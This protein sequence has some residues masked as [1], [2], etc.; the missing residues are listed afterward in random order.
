MCGSHRSQHRLPPPKRFSLSSSADSRSSLDPPVGK[1]VLLPLSLPAPSAAPALRCCRRVPET[2][3]KGCAGMS[4]C[5]RPR[6]SRQAPRCSAPTALLAAKVWEKGS[7]SEAASFPPPTGLVQ[8][9]LTPVFTGA[10]FL[11]TGCA[12]VNRV[13]LGIPY[14]FI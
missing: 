14:V 9:L 4:H 6:S 13:Y 1:P 2:P 8:L 11:F 12:T 10:I 7:V 5:T 3:S